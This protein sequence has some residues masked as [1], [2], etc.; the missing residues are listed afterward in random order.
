MFY[1]DL[2]NAIVLTVGIFKRKYQNNV[3]NCYIL[4]LSLTD[5]LFLLISV[6]L[7]TYLGIEKTWIFGQFLCKMHIYLAH[8]CLLLAHLDLMQ[9][10]VFVCLGISSCDLLYF[11]CDEHRSLFAHRA[12]YVV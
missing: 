1:L 6:P 11:S 2:G 9:S 8:V 7:T 3:T 5:F 12:Q 4:N 10:C